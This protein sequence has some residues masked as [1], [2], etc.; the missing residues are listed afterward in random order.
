MIGVLGPTVVLHDHLDGGVRPATLIELA[1]AAGVALPVD[2]P[3]RLG[4][5]LTIRPSMPFAEAFSRFD[6][7][8]ACL[9]T[10]EALRRVAAEAVED[11]AADGVI[12]AE[13][14]FAPL[15]HTAAALTPDDVV[16]TVVRALADAASSTMSTGLILCALRP[17]D[18]RSST[19]VAELGVR[20]AGVVGFDLAGAEAGYPAG[21]HADAFARAAE[22][23]RGRPAHTGDLEGVEAVLEPLE[24]CH[25][26]RLG[27]GWRLSDDSRV[28]DGRI[29]EL[30]P[31]A[32]RVRDAGIPLEVCLTSNACLGLAVEDHPVRLLVDAG[33]RV[34]LN[35][36]DR[37][38]T[39]TS[40]SREH[41]LAAEV[42]GFDRVELAAAAERAAVA[43]F[44]PEAE[45]RELVTRVRDGW[46]V[47]PRR[48]VHLAE[49]SRWEAV[50]GHGVYL[51]AEWDQDG[52]IHL[53][54]R[55]QLLTPANHHSRRRTDLVAL[56]LD[57]SLLGH[58][59]VWEP[60]TGTDE[61][62]PHLS[63]ALSADAVVAE[64]PMVPAADGGFLLPAGL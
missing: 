29:V 51:P 17:D 35:P 43:A 44:L 63:S 23:G 14:R 15:L 22:G 10:A 13:L 42:H 11:L 19:A 47:E 61:H 52:F 45:R 9:Q 41:R 4:E 2:H 60:G 62:F 39:T 7:V 58:A 33:F 16:E 24:A 54:A 53:S 56:E 6:L 32:A 36:D 26:D 59:V 38:I 40:T 46:D 21:P 8:V 50:R 48:L 20:H 12:H 30:G 37:S 25:P 27:H 3:D 34:C 18:P 64:H 5:W 57:V 1:A 49:W 31:V 55:H 28:V